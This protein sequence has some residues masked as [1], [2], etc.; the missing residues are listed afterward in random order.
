MI[1]IAIIGNGA[2]GMNASIY[3]KTKLPKKNYI[4][5]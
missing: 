2:V 3:L 4:I 1:D 5:W